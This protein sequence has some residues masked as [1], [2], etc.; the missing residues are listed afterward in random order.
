MGRMAERTMRKGLALA[1]LAML[2][3]LLAMPARAQEAIQVLQQ[4][5][6]S[7]F[8]D[9]ITASL[10]ARGTAEITDV[11]FFYRLAGQKA[12]TRNDADFEPGTEVE[13]QFVIDQTAI[14]FP[15][16]TELEYWWKLTD[17]D[18]NT[19]KTD[20][21][22]YLYL[23]NRYDFQMLQNERLSLY[24][25]RGGDDFGQ[26]LFDRANEALDRLEQDV[27]VT[28][29][30]PIKIF[31]YGS[32][33]DLLNAIAVG[34]QEWTGGQAF[35]DNGVVVMGVSPDNLDWGLKATVHELTHLVIHQATD[36]P[37]GDLPRWLDEGLAVYN[38][39]PDR[40]DFQFRSS[41]DRA[42]SANE[43]MTLQTL[44]STFPADSE[45]ANLAYG[46][47]GVVVK[48]ILD[49]YGPEAMAK[50]L[51][52]FAEGALYDD[53]L[54]EALGVDMHTLDNQWRASLGLPPLPD[55]QT[56]ENVA[57]SPV[58]PTAA[59]ETGPAPSQPEAAANPT[60]TPE[61]ASPPSAEPATSQSNGVLFCVVGL[62]CLG[63]LGALLVGGVLL[64]LRRRQKPVIGN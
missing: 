41:F 12:T 53:A 60:A 50:L 64:V 28:V 36:N 20:R 35:A 57:P 16:G 48:F 51:D 19:L 58:P 9:N 24:W 6:E 26:A 46:E 44:S 8:R 1:L 11:E 2:L 39:D 18:G 7:E 34:A 14:Y 43:L 55:F 32:H 62:F 63:G 56:T 27:G 61:A 17:A 38:E 45:A 54:E 13:A 21:Q 29:E 23:D 42:V 22:T 30:D 5:I 4:S 40:L 15:P 37:Y 3:A 10:S 25:Y 47:S 33:S 31:I 52:I 49:T 59:P